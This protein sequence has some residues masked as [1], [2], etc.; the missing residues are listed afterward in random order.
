MNADAIVVGAGLAGLVAAAELVAHHE[1]SLDDTAVMVTLDTRRC[2]DG[3][4]RAG[5]S[6]YATTLTP[7]G[8]H[9]VDQQRT[10]S[11]YCGSRRAARLLHCRRHMEPLIWSSSICDSHEIFKRITRDGVCWVRMTGAVDLAR[12]DP[13][14]IVE[15]LIGWTPLATHVNHIKV[16]PATR[17]GARPYAITNDDARFHIDQHPYL[18]PALQLLVCERQAS[19]PG[20]ESMFIDSWKLLDELHANGNGLVVRLFEALRIIRFHNFLWCAP[21]FSM[22]AGN[23]I[24]VHNGFPLRTDTV[25]TEFQQLLDRQEP[26]RFRLETGDLL[27]SNNHRTLHARTAFVDT[28]RHLIRILTW[29][30]RP[31][32]APAHYLLRAARIASRIEASVR[33]EPV[34]IRKRLGFS[35]LRAGQESYDVDDL[36]SHYR[37]RLAEN[38]EQENELIRANAQ[39]MERRAS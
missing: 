15:E 22:R 31:M 17:P 14:R 2:D 10:C 39:T 24:C 3:W 4:A 37:G 21:T 33:D 7:C 32:P 6:F 26:I 38:A 35:G 9:H 28:E 1:A 27:I 34:W 20:G 18:P 30:H 8:R 36:L 29:L 25:G 19:D 12:R 16:A 11:R 5:V 23:L 13:Q